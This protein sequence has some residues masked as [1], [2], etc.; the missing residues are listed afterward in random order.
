[1]QLVAFVATLFLLLSPTLAASNKKS[2]PNK[3][4]AVR[5]PNTGSFFDLSSISLK[6]LEPGQKRHKDD[7][8]ES[9]HAKGYDYPANF[10]LNFCAPVLED[11]KEV[12]GVDKSLWKNVSA[13]YEFDGKVY[14]LGQQ[15][16]E[17]VFRGRKLVL[18]YTDG[19]PCSSR[20]SS[21]LLDRTVVTL[22]EPKKPI[23][24]DE[25]DDKSR[26][27]HHKET[28]KDGIRRKSTIISLLCDRDPLAPKASLAFVGASPDEC[29]YFFEARSQAACGRVNDA[30]QTL[31]PGGVFGVI[32]LIAVLVYVA[33]GCVYQRT[34]M[35]Q[36]GWRQLPNY[37]MWSGMASFVKVGLLRALLCLRFKGAAHRKI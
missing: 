8:T 25:D 31:G 4:C 28:S 35:H 2:I 26:K 29:S 10:T 37:S 17:P 20:T 22:K 7:R 14:S 36:R 27:G 33:G 30:Q 3:P 32:V 1:M 15:S 21:G 11:V 6:P 5:S 34:V 9:W 19:S 23:D 24:D 18:N 12:V 16:S 13:F